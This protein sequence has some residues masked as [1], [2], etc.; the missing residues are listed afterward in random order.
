MVTAKERFGLRTSKY[1][2]VLGAAW[3]TMSL[4]LATG[5]PAAAATAIGEQESFFN[6]CDALVFVSDTLIGSPGKIEAWGGWACPQSF[7]FVGELKIELK[8]GNALV[9]NDQKASRGLSTLD[10]NATTDNISGL[11][12]WH[13]D[14]K[15]FR[16]GY[17]TW[18]VSTGVIRS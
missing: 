8:N 16:P 14:L 9:K 12:N 18:I 11:Q 6:Q 2:A 10:V 17:D 15:I 3:A 5:G 7:K 13:A 1:M 4:L